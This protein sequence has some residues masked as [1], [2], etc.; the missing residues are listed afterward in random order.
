MGYG[1]LVVFLSRHLTVVRN[2]VH[3][4]EGIL[5]VV[6]VLVRFVSDFLH[7]SIVAVRYAVVRVPVSI[8]V[9]VVIASANLTEGDYGEIILHD[10]RLI[11]VHYD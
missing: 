11:L 9:M 3:L 5:L 10:K 6:S 7:V 2:R 1:C 8:F 4:R